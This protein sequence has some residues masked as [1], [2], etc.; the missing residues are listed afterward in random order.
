[1]LAGNMLI[2]ALEVS[3][4]VVAMPAV[5]KDLSLP[6]AEAQWLISGFALGFGGLLLFGHRV[7]ER[8]GRRRA[9]LAALLCYVSLCWVSS[10]ASDPTL[11]IASR[12]GRGACAA[13]TAPTGLAIISATFREGAERNRAL[14]VY[15][16]V[17][18]SGFSVGLLISGALTEES[19]RW[20]LGFPAPVVLV[21]LVFGWRLVPAD[22]GDRE[23]RPGSGALTAG[24][25]T[26]ALAALV[27]A[28]VNLP[29][30]GWRSVPVAGSFVLFVLLVGAMLVVERSASR[31]LVRGPI[32]AG[33]PRLH[34]MV[35][36]ACLNGSFIGLLLVFMIRLSTLPGWSSWHAALA[37]LP[38]SI[39]LVLLA[40]FTGRLLNR[41]RTRAL[42]AA[43]SVPAFAGYVVSLSSSTSPGYLTGMLPTVLLVGIGFALGFAAL[44]SQVLHGIAAEDRMSASGLYQTVVQVAA[45]VMTAAVTALLALS[46]SAAFWLVTGVG[47]VGL[48]N[49][50]IGLR[51]H[52]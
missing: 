48:V 46:A 41:F 20:A 15:T 35:G 31:P 24:C 12:I 11:L 44:N 26:G 36:A 37:L 51:K 49:A 47:A 29:V 39:P 28:M 1:M 14:S 6:T 45:V 10:L 23:V 2:D 13:L 17:G 7:V 34:A 25:L 43:G 8:F 50:A 18:A 52:I 4:A 30:R 22:R 5:G 32:F 21:L 19:W 3:V 27:Q 16:L 40:P 42:I 33:G 38:A 9:Y